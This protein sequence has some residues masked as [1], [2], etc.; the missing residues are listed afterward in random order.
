M[1]IDKIESVVLRIPYTSG[2]PSDT[3]V[4]GGQAW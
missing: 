1:K 4:W 3:Q 2:G